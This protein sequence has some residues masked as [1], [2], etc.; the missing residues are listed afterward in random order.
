MHYPPT[1]N[2]EAMVELAGGV[3]RK[4]GLGA[5][6]GEPLLGA[7]D[8]SYVLQRVPGAMLMLGVK[9]PDWVEPRP[10]HTAQFDLDEEALPLGTA[11]YV[12]LAL[13]VLSS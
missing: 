11:A 10:V 5:V 6:P 7:E 3:V 9:N 8:F 4:L 12:A 1:I 2:D 13:E